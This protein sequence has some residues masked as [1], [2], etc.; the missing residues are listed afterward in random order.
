MGCTESKLEDLQAVALCRGRRRSLGEALLLRHALSEAHGAYLLSLRNVGDQLHRL[1]HNKDDPPPPLAPSP[2]SSHIRFSPSQ[3][4]SSEFD[5]DLS[6]P[7]FE[8]EPRESSAW[9]F[10]NPFVSFAYSTGDGDG[11]LRDEEGVPELEEEEKAVKVE[12]VEESRVEED[13]EEGELPVRDPVPESRSVSEAAEEI[14]RLFDRASESCEEISKL[15]EVGKWPRRPGEDEVVDRRRERSAIVLPLSLDHSVSGFVSGETTSP[16]AEGMVLPSASLASTLR[17]LFI[18][19]KKLYDEVIAEEKLRV[20]YE[21]KGRRL[22]RLEEDGAESRKVGPA[23]LTVRKLATKI[24]VAIQAV[25]SISSRIGKL[26]DDELWPQLLQLIHGL[27][28]MWRVMEECHRN[29]HRAIIE[30]KSLDKI[31]SEEKPSEA[32]TLAL[33]QLELSIL[34]WID[35]LCSWFH[36]QKSFARALNDWLS[37]YL[38]YDPEMTDDGLAPFSPGRLGAPPPF[39]I[40]NQWAQAMAAL[41]DREVV[42]AIQALAGSVLQLWERDRLADL[43]RTTGNQ[44]VE[45]DELAVQKAVDALNRKLVLASDGSGGAVYGQMVIRREGN[46]AGEG[47]KGELKRVFD[48]MERFAQSWVKIYEDLCARSEEEGA[49]GESSRGRA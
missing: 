20:R 19:E 24:K 39:F 8:P 42:A 29:Q 16:Q 37:K 35:A 15:L 14:K 7:A 27:V 38:L 32:R 11:Q 4:D 47:L 23:E 6:G 30:S 25:E 22:K 40:C 13:K 3:S 17:K 31:A 43:Q 34:R 44:D 36:A 10:L 9:D 46:G 49:A 41:S 33:K 26:R 12:A 2:E 21:Q 28:K 5:D 18:W 48:A 45:K 1:L